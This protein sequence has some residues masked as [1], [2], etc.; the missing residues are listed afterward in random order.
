MQIETQIQIQNIL[1]VESEGPV[2]QQAGAFV[3][4]CMGTIWT[5]DTCRIQMCCATELVARGFP[6]P[7]F[8][9]KFCG[10]HGAG[11][12]LLVAGAACSH[13]GSE[14]AAAPTVEPLVG[15]WYFGGWFNCTGAGC[16]SHFQG[17][18]PRGERVPDFFAAYPERT[19]LLGKYDMLASTVAA[20]VRRRIWRG[21]VV[22]VLTD[23]GLAI[24]L[25]VA[26]CVGVDTVL[27]CACRRIS[28][29][30][31]VWCCGG[32]DRRL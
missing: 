11:P 2:V 31:G 22:L 15:A 26:G 7:T 16:Y 1:D 9:T 4:G 17:F 8:V 21:C 29:R 24:L 6:M 23:H 27:A 32:R 10:E 20:E 12:G 18:A 13:C 25:H 5:S 3:I 28:G 19:P 30:C 14:P